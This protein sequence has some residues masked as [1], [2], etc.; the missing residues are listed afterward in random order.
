M[1][2]NRHFSILTALIVVLIYGIPVIAQAQLF[3]GERE[4]LLGVY[5]HR[6]LGPLS[7]P[8]L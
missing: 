7:K 5:C 4:G 6:K 1:T 2:M 8:R 3:D